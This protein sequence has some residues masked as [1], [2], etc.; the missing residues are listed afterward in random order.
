MGSLSACFRAA[1]DTSSNDD[2]GTEKRQNNKKQRRLLFR[3]DETSLS[4][5]PL[6]GKFQGSIRNAEPFGSISRLFGFFP[7]RVF[8]GSGLVPAKAARHIYPRGGSHSGGVSP[9][10][11]RWR[12]TGPVT[13]Y[14]D[15]H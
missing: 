2:C 3:I 14:D 13:G 10:R 1:E 15:D 7:E 12:R 6:F 4:D 5:L 11:L 8:A 9:S